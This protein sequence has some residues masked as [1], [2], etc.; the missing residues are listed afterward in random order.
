MNTFSI[1]RGWGKN[2]M[3]IRQL[4]TSDVDSDVINPVISAFLQ[5]QDRLKN[6]YSIEEL[7]K[8]FNE[9]YSQGNQSNKDWLAIWNFNKV[10]TEFRGG[11]SA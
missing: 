8:F 4:L 2:T 11:D 10:I 5:T 3:T 1:F 6:D 7:E 9:Q